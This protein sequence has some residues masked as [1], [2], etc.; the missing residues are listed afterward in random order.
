MGFEVNK[1][2]KFDN[3]YIYLYYKDNYIAYAITENEAF[4]IICEYL[5]N[6][7]KSF[8]DKYFDICG[9]EGSSI[10]KYKGKYLRKP[11]L[12]EWYMWN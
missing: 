2:N 1:Q 3:K 8:T 11:R 4:N 12:M 9:Y 7:H 6:E 5:Y 10:T